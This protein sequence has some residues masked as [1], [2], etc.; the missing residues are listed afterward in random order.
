MST[1]P[2][3]RRSVVAIAA[4]GVLLGH[5]LTYLVVT[6]AAHRRA[7]ELATT[8]HAYLSVANAMGMALAS[9]ALAAIFLS[10]LTHR[11]AGSSSTGSWLI[12][13]GAFQ[14][15]VFV[16]MEVV[17]RVSTGAPLSGL[18]QHGILPI[19]VPIQLGVAALG[20]LAIRWLLRAA[21]GVGTILSVATVPPHAGFIDLFVPT[22][23]VPMRP[24]L[25]AAGIRG[26]P[27]AVSSA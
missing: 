22:L 26:P 9:V 12:R 14:A 19:G 5:W 13:L 10:R 21:D 3:R 20:A 1:D 8:G 23:P 25:A 7:A 2:A 11:R 16:S 4:G 6:P 27:S 24:V 18:L 17:E 15:A